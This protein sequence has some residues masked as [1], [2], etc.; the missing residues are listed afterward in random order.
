MDG[1]MKGDSGMAKELIRKKM[2]FVNE[3]IQTA[4]E[5]KDWKT[6][7]EAV[8]EYARLAKIAEEE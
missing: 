2:Y 4:R 1:R 5:A 7:N 6:Y 3:W 8:K